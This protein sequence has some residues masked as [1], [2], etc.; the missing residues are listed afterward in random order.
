MHQKNNDE[1]NNILLQAGMLV[2]H[3][4]LAL[5]K[6]FKLTMNL[7]QKAVVFKSVDKNNFTQICEIENHKLERFRKKP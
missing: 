3:L 7:E 6:S 4:Y 1:P 2:E 5:E